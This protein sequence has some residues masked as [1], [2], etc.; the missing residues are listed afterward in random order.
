MDNPEKRVPEII[1]ALT[2]GTSDDQERALMDYFLPNAYFVHPFCRV[3]S[4]N[5]INLPF[6]SLPIPSRWLLLMVYK[7]YRILSPEIKL[8]VDST[9]F[10]RKTNLLYCSIRQTF[11]LWFVPFSLWQANVK[12]VTVLKLE[13]LPVDA[14]G[15]PLSNQADDHSLGPHRLFFIKGQEDH[16]QVE[17][18]LK[19]IAPFGASMLWQLWQLFASLLCVAGVMVFWP[20]MVIRNIVLPNGGRR[21]IKEQ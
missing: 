5:N 11:T 13:H 20:V 10:D 16:Y 7:W 4:F 15:R 12:L 2:M 14:H 19:F 18:F 9:V 1:A 21:V 8:T 3:P 17:E 6:I